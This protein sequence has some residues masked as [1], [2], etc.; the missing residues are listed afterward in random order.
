MQFH[1][2]ITERGSFR[3]CRRQWYLEV[4]ERLAHRDRVAW[5]LIFGE[6]I[7]TGLETYY[8]NNRRNVKTAVAAFKRAWRATGAELQESYGGLFAR[9]EPEWSDWLDKGTRMLIYYDMYDRQ[10]EFDWDAVLHVNIEKRAFVDILNLEG[11]PVED[12]DSRLRALLSGRID[13]V[14]ERK[15]GIWIVD[16][17]TAASA[18]DAR[19]LDVD[20]Q[21]TGYC[22]IYW[23]LTGEV[24]RGAIYNALIKDPP[25]P[26]RLL[27]DGSLSKDKSQ[28]TTY[29]LY[30]AEIKTLKLDK[31]DYTDILEYLKEKS[32]KQFFV[33]DGLT[34]N[35][36]ELKSFEKRLYYEYQDMKSVIRSPDRAYPNPSQ[37]TCPGCSMIPLC[38]AME[39][40]NPEWVRENMYETVPPRTTIPKALQSPRWKG[41]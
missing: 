4:Q 17:K 21:L 11:Y 28:R 39:E 37:R 29:D 2:T 20:D 34:R 16:H 24:P 1:T 15:D 27:K 7:H 33:R 25:G 14:V 32:W 23:R 12:Q 19:A 6:A 31:A 26:P 30:L 10:A 36:E 13:L 40:M 35:L 18:Y 3:S 22:Y 9:L 41:V 38:Q 8:R 5:P